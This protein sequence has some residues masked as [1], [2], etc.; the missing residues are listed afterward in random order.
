H[1]GASCQVDRGGCG[2]GQAG[3][4]PSSDDLSFAH[5]AV[6]VNLGRGKTDDLLHT[7]RDRAPRHRQVL[8]LMRGAT[9]PPPPQESA[10]TR[11]KPSPT[12]NTRASDPLHDPAVKAQI[13][14]L[15]VEALGAPIN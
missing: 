6:L 12:H 14:D 13:A 11:H 1:T 3:C 15:I 7:L 10:A 5:R 9:T 4:N 8:P 2:A